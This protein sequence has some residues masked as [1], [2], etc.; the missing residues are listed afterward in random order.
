MAGTGANYIPDDELPLRDKFLPTP[1]RTDTMDITTEW[2]ALNF[3]RQQGKFTDYGD[4]R[5]RALAYYN[6]LT[7]NT[8]GASSKAGLKASMIPQSGDLAK[9][10]EQFGT[11]QQE[12]VRLRQEASGGITG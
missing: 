2:D 1:Y 7:G 5:E 4:K 11:S 9:L 3:A 10:A 12:I 8:I 6:S